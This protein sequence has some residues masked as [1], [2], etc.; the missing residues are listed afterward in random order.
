M[1]VMTERFLQ[2]SEKITEIYRL[3]KNTNLFETDIAFLD[4]SKTLN[5]KFIRKDCLLHFEMA[6]HIFTYKL[7]MK[8]FPKENPDKFLNFASYILNHIA[9]IL[10]K[11]WDI[12]EEDEV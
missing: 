9:G 7:N 3:I 12:K 10:T 11:E 6:G 1:P 8:D 2:Q 4:D 5:I